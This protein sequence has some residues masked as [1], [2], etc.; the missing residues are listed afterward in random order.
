MTSADCQ[1]VT[2]FSF[3][4]PSPTRAGRHPTRAHAISPTR[5]NEVICH[6]TSLLRIQWG[7]RAVEEVD[8]TRLLQRQDLWFQVTMIRQ[9]SARIIL[10]PYQQKQ[11]A[12]YRWRKRRGE[13]GCTLCMRP[14][15][16]STII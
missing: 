9:I 15:V 8:R 4:T 16:L 7:L 6:T 2:T 11:L 5:R 1:L 3:I 14:A 12:I 13:A 10:R